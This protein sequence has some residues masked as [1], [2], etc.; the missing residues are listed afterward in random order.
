MVEKA[1]REV[2]K[3]KK[4]DGRKDK[5]KRGD[6]ANEKRRGSVGKRKKEWKSSFKSCGKIRNRGGKD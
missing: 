2:E 3:V 4:S 1:K 6:E 5:N